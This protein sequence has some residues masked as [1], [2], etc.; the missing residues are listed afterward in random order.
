MTRPTTY[1]GRANNDIE[2][3]MKKGVPLQHV[4]YYDTAGQLVGRTYERCNDLIRVSYQPAPR[5]HGSVRLGM[6]PVVQSLRERLVAI[7]PTN[8]RTITW[9]RPETLY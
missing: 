5:K 2:L 7:G 1:T 4:F 9:F 3:E 6:V 8:T